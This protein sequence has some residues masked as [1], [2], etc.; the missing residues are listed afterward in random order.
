MYI[1]KYSPPYKDVYSVKN[2]HVLFTTNIQNANPWKSF[3]GSFFKEKLKMKS[4]LWH[5]LHS[6]H[7]YLEQTT[8][9]VTEKTV[10]FR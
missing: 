1:N 6:F 7:T 2:L 5:K 10:V 3:D 4:Y 8:Y 9:V